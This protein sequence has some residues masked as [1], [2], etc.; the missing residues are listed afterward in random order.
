MRRVIRVITW[1]LF[2]LFLRDLIDLSFQIQ[3]MYTY[4]SFVLLLFLH[5]M[6]I[7]NFFLDFISFFLMIMGEIAFTS[8]L[9]VTFLCKS[10]IWN[11]RMGLGQGLRLGSGVGLEFRIVIEFLYISGIQI[12]YLWIHIFLMLFLYDFMGILL[13]FDTLLFWDWLFFIDHTL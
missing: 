13:N 4:D 7:R 3:D 8:I 5:W 10:T 12:S 2:Y 9:A 1:T 6:Y 11:N